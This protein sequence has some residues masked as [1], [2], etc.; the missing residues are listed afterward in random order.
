M[1]KENF[2]RFLPIVAVSLILAG[3]MPAQ[4]VSPAQPVPTPT[5]TVPA[6]F[7]D[8][9]KYLSLTESQ[10]SALAGL[11]QQQQQAIS[12]L[13]QQL[14]QDE[15]TLQTLL[16][17]S[18]PDALSIGQTMIAI[19][20]LQNQITQSGTATY[21]TQALAVLNQSQTTLLANLNT[22]LQLLPA[23]NQ[24][25]EVF[26][27]AGPTPI[28]VTFPPVSGGAPTPVP[29]PARYRFLPAQAR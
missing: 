27:I 25:V 15:Q 18:S 17:A 13:A 21:Q 14:M 24:A 9:Q 11:Q 2:M 3:L 8:L 16:Q 28:T 29:A 12:Q 7:P 26:L 1:K 4:V 20:N 6:L 5:P 22:A 10:V 19:Q 23:A